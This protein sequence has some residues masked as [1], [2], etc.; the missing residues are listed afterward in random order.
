MVERL[1]GARTDATVRRLD[2]IG[3]YPMVESP[4]RFNAALIDALAR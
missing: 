1:A 3:H 4:A 2:G